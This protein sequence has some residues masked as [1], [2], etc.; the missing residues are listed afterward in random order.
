MNSY[1]LQNFPCEENFHV[2]FLV[3][4]NFTKMKLLSIKLVFF[5][6]IINILLYFGPLYW[7]EHFGMFHFDFINIIF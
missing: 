4:L 1:F 7:I 2:F 6:E 5:I 3:K